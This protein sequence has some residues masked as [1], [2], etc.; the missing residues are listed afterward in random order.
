MCLKANNCRKGQVLDI[1]LLKKNHN[2]FCD[3]SSAWPAIVVTCQDHLKLKNIADYFLK[4][5][6]LASSGIPN[7]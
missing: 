4:T 7:C 5:V 6:V 3:F 1:V 2:L